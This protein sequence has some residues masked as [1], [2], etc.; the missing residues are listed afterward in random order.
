VRE[1]GYNIPYWVFAD[2]FKEYS[3]KNGFG[4][5]SDSD[6]KKMLS[7]I[8]LNYKDFEKKQ[9]YYNDNSE[10]LI[11][12]WVPNISFGNTVL[13]ENAI[14]RIRK[15]ILTQITQCFQI[16]VEQKIFSFFNLNKL[17]NSV[18][19]VLFSENQQQESL[20]N[21]TDFLPK[22]IEIQQCKSVLLINTK[23][24]NW[25]I[26][27]LI[28]KV[29]EDFVLLYQQTIERKIVEETIQNLIKEGIFFEPKKNLIQYVK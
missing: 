12:V 24:K 6:I 8:D 3:L 28:D 19:S 18:L 14:K 9:I 10:R 17:E 26:D 25:E 1:V 21:N 4:D 29:I 16:D 5:F 15:S 13:M 20:K 11:W 7:C 22:S 27:D 23:S 2:L